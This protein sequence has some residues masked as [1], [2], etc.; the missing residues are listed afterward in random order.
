MTAYL[1][2]RPEVRKIGRYRFALDGRV[3]DFGPAVHP[4]NDQQYPIG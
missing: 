4:G 3:V 2:T 1:T